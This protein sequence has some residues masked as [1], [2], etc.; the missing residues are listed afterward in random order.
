MRSFDPARRAAPETAEHAGA[1]ATP[2]T[3]L[4]AETPL[5]A[6]SLDERRIVRRLLLGA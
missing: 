3:A 1:A 6:E 5:G 2:P 4:V